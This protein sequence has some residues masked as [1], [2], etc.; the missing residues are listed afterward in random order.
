MKK[1]DLVGN[2]MGIIKILPKKSTAQT[3]LSWSKIVPRIYLFN[4]QRLSLV[5]SG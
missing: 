5:I 2:Q 4:N 3:N 1:D